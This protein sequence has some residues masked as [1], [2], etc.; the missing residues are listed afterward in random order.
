MLVD[1]MPEWKEKFL[2]LHD[3][4]KHLVKKEKH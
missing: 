4:I 1:A 2:G 3:K